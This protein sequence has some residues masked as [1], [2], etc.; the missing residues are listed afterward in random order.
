M[1]AQ[2]P[3]LTDPDL[4]RHEDPNTAFAHLREHDPVHW[5]DAD[6]GG[7]WNLTR[8][9]EDVR[10]ALTD[11][12]WLISRDGAISVSSYPARGDSASGK[13]LVASDLPEHPRDAFTGP[14]RGEDPAVRPEVRA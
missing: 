8:R 10:N 14:G 2:N 7:F 1:T 9:Y 12:R 6:G 3:N 5:H 4:F 13:M 11:H